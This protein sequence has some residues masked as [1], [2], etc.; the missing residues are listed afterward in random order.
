MNNE[1]TKYDAF[2]SYRHTDLDIFV[3]EKIH[4]LLETYVAP[5]S[6]LKKSAKRKIKR[7]FRDKDELPTSSNLS[8][9]I[10]EALSNSEYLIVICSPRTPES[11]WVRTEIETFIGMHGRD[12]VLTLL[13]EGEPSEAFP[14]VLQYETIKTIDE[15]QNIIETKKS[16][17][18]LAADVRGASKKQVYKNIKKELLRIAAP[19]L[20]CSY[21]DLRQRHK[22]RRVK[23]ILASSLLSSAFF[24][25]FG[26]F[27]LYQTHIIKQNYR[28]KLIN[29]SRYLADTSSSLL[30]SG[31][32]MDAIMVALEA[33]PNDEQP[34]RPYV[35]KAC[36]ALNNALYSYHTP[37]DLVADRSL[38]HDFFVRDISYSP[39]GQTL[40]TIDEGSTSYL[41]DVETG[42][43]INTIDA[44]EANSYNTNLI[45][46]HLLNDNTLVVCTESTVKCYN[47][48]NSEILWSYNDNFIRYFS[49]NQDNSIAAI[50]NSDEVITL[51]MSTGKILSTYICADDIYLRDIYGFSPDSKLICL[52]Y[53]ESSLTDFTSVFDANVGVMILDYL[54]N[55]SFVLPITTSGIAD[56]GFIDN[57]RL[58]IATSQVDFYDKL[59]S[60]I[61]NDIILFDIYNES[62]IWTSN[63][64]LLSSFGGKRLKFDFLDIWEDS[65][66]HTYIMYSIDNKLTTISSDTGELLSQIQ[67]PST[68]EDFVITQAGLAIL[69]QDNGVISLANVIQGTRY[70]DYDIYLNYPI[71]GII[72]N[73][74]VLS[75]R[76][77]KSSNI[78]LYKYLGGP[79]YNPIKNFESDSYIRSAKYSLDSSYMAVH[80]DDSDNK[81]NIVFYNNKKSEIGQVQIDELIDIYDFTP[82]NNLIVCTNDGYIYLVDPENQSIISTFSNDDYS[83]N[84]YLNKD[85]T[86][87]SVTC[88]NKYYILDTSDLSVIHQGTTDDNIKNSII[89]NNGKYLIFSNYDYEIKFYNSKDQDELKA[90]INYITS[91][92]VTTNSFALAN[93]SDLLAICCGDN[94]VRLIDLDRMKTIEEFEL[95]IMEWHSLIFSPDDKNIIIQGDDGIVRV[96]NLE[97]SQYIK[98]TPTSLQRIDDWKFYDKLGLIAGISSQK[99]CL[100][101]TMDNEYEIIAEIPEFMDI[102]EH[103]NEVLVRFSK[104]LGYFPYYSL[105]MLIEEANKVTQNETLSPSDRLRYYID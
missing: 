22:E 55:N 26:G 38:S 36:Y 6:V 63:Y 34:D 25:A 102:D 10:M 13:I 60:D 19:L 54:N 30:E 7:V 37:S 104:E 51:D 20:N 65:K 23:K 88:H 3:A 5:K 93:N 82:D 27:S 66:K 12:K 46:S 78:V 29:Q 95:P 57:N 75:V 43:L 47:I 16:V 101:T 1:I 89:S 94:T 59:Y 53:Y 74:G 76:P 71:K 77:Y 17:E 58:I 105:D 73:N 49:L 4:K 64:T 61:I 45:S 50:Y 42:S 9:N 80:I 92:K 41:W 40:L 56:A 67:L 70:Y 48:K 86:I 97:K 14:E 68:I 24:L 100:F 39:S 81:A 96:Y 85:H 33:L 2:I 32:R 15:N 62:I 35:A 99:T 21:D 79:G 8:D 83:A 28:S 72:L 44:K 98:L 84:Y 11:Y 87:L 18:P 31:N 91:S 69:A 103:N 52:S 90:D